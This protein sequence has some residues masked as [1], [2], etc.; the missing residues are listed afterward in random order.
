[1]KNW[2]LP[3]NRYHTLALALALT[4]IC[5]VT[6]LAGCASR[7]GNCQMMLVGKNVEYVC[8]Y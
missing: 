6:F 8:N 4:L 5:A 1:M 7:P 2:W 3:E